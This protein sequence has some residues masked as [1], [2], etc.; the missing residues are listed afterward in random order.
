MTELNQYFSEEAQ[1]ILQRDPFLLASLLLLVEPGRVR[2]AIQELRRNFPGFTPQV[3]HS[4]LVPRLCTSSQ[5]SSSQGVGF[6]DSRPSC[7]TSETL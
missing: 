2:D 4:L 6:T 7:Y 1:A 5:S 3:P